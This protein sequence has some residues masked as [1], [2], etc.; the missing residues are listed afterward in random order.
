V[1]ARRGYYALSQQPPAPARAR[2]DPAFQAALDSPYDVAEL[3]LRMTHF[4]REETS[5]IDEARVFLAAEVDVGRLGLREEN[6][7]AKGALQYL[8]VALPR[9]GGASRR[10]DQTLNLS[11]PPDTRAQLARSWLPL[12]HEFALH[13]GRYRAKIVVRDKGSGRVGTVVHD[14]EVP[15]LKAFRLSTPVLSDVRESTA[16]GA[17]GERLGL[18]VR[19]EFPQTS[20]LYCQVEVYRPVREETSGLPRVSMGFEARRSDGA[21]L[22]REPPT[23][24]IPSAEGTLSRMI[25]FPLRGVPPGDYVLT[26]RVKDELSGDTLEQREPFS[27]AADSAGAAAGR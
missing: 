21:L 24:I 3:P 7:E 23:R 19:R 18:I 10:F 6:G 1:R 16:E 12:V 15:D 2:T 11:L 8:I 26:L 22:T 14:F 13:S 17:P 27:V 9:D 25:G 4:V 20:S 5:T